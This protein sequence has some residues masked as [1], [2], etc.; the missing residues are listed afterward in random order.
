[1]RISDW[2]SDVCSSDLVDVLHLARDQPRQQEIGEQEARERVAD[3]VLVARDDRGVRDRQPHRMAKQRGEDRKSGVE[4]KSETESV[5]HGGR[6]IMNKKI[7]VGYHTLA[8]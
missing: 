5:D 7:L 3:P 2:S 1:M 8:T 6:R 4:G